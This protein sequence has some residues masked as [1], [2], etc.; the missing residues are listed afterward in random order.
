MAGAGHAPS[1]AR[2]LLSGLAGRCPRCG[3]GRLFEGFLTIAG[4]CEACGLNLSE[5]DSGDGPAVAAIFILGFGV[6][7]L[8]WAVER[9]V[10]PPLWIHAALWIPLTI[11]GT[12]LL[13][14]PLKGLTVALQ[15]CVR[16]VDEPTLPGGT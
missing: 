9:L 10:M 4:Q 7:G 6:I 3:G 5:H 14:R 13:L 1:A 16:S 11:A 12:L 2:S 8:A 15:Y